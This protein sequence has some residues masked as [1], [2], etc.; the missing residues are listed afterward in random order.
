MAHIERRVR[1]RTCGGPF[2]AGSCQKCGR[3]ASQVAYRARYIDPTGRERSKSFSRRVDADRFLTTVESGKLQ[4]TWTDPARGKVTFAAWLETWWTT[5]ADLRPSTRARDRSYLNSLILPQFGAASLAA[6][7][8]PT[9]QAWVASLTARGLAAETVVKAYQLLGRTM[10]AAVNADMLA[11]SPCRAVR[12]PKIERQEMR[13]LTPAEVARLADA[14]CPRYRTLVLL[15][16]YGGL[17]IGELA[18]LRRGPVNLARGTV[19]VAEIVVEVKGGPPKTRAGRRTVG[20]PQALVDE[21][22][23]HMGPL[24]PADAHVFT[25]YKG[26]VLRTSNFRAK[27]W[28]PAVR[29]AGLAPLRPHDLRH[30]AVALWIAAGANPK[31]VSVRA[32]HTS[33]SFTL[34]RYGHLF[35]GHDL[36]LRDRLDAMLAEGLKETATD[37]VVRLRAVSTASDDGP[38]TAQGSP[39]NQEGLAPDRASPADSG[40]A[41]SRTQYEP[42]PAGH[43]SDHP[44]AGTPRAGAVTLLSSLLLDLRMES[45]LVRAHAEAHLGRADSP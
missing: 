8:Q 27:V 33:V 14:I 18:G 44:P 36:E 41:P 37:S 45:P 34:D 24:G 16:A 23:A 5:A 42:K 7:T 28:L 4:G 26:G 20:L 19:D 31:E 22:A 10:T 1:C 43:R 29:A 40:G 12:L 2:A 38:E 35:E 3:H 21:L 39:S 32:G 15:G 25:S 13:F 11:R 6:T 17:R 30:T 9:V